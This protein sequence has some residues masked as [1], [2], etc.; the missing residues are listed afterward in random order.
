MGLLDALMENSQQRIAEIFI[1]VIFDTCL[2]KVIDK[3]INIS[4]PYL[5]KTMITGTYSS[6]STGT[7]P[8]LIKKS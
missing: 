2:H 3:A 5:K 4:Y 6:N 8:T 1:S 7:L